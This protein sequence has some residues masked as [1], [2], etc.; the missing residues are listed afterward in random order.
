MPPPDSV[1]ASGGIS[2]DTPPFRLRLF[3]GFA[4]E[5]PSGPDWSLLSQRRAQ[6]VLATLALCGKMGCSRD[7]MISYLWPESDE[8]HARHNLRDAVYAIRKLLGRDAVLSRGDILLLNPSVVEADV[9]ELARALSA[10]DLADA[11]D[12]YTGPLLDGFHIDGAREWV[13]WIEGERAHLLQEC[14]GASKR[15][16]KRGED[17]GRWDEASE[18]WGRAV[19]LDPY[20]S[21][22]VVRH[23]IALTRR[24]DRANAIQEGEAHI[25]RLRSE[26]DLDPD[27][28]FVEELE[29]IRTGHLGPVRFFTP[30]AGSPVQKPPPASESD[31]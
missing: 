31:D 10:G 8:G 14:I 17:S 29:R 21:R 1:V 30:P 15:L 16:A 4:L 25:R 12:L 9:E 20:N 11:V 3:G 23:M 28:S 22:S 27:A 19:A 5:E 18:W 26:L 2:L 6:A 13:R 24:G 7:R